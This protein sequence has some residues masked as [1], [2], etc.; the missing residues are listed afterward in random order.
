MQ[1]YGRR[2]QSFAY[3]VIETFKLNAGMSKIF[4]QINL[5]LQKKIGFSEFVEDRSIVSN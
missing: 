3:T 2:K 4:L 5:N 1:P